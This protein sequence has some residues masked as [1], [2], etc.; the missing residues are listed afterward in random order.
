MSKK[1]N[2]HITSIDMTNNNDG[3]DS[4]Q[5]IKEIEEMEEMEEMEALIDEERNKND[6]MFNDV[7]LQF[8]QMMKERDDARIDT[9]SKMPEPFKCDNVTTYDNE[10]TKIL[11]A[12]L[13]KINEF[14]D[15]LAKTAAE[16]AKAK[17]LDSLLAKLRS[18]C[19][20]KSSGGRKTRRRQKRKTHNKKKGG[21][22]RKTGNKKR[23]Q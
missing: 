18:S 4:I 5:Y 13:D 3:R 22:H 17:N 23:R 15:K 8:E 12:R 14:R 10:R 19:N 11:Q 20:S 21:K 7:H 2:Q 9:I 1:D 16:N 6:K